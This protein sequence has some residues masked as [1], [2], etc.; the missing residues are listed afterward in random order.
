MDC[1]TKNCSSP[2]G[3][4]G[5]EEITALMQD[6]RNNPPKSLGG[7][8]V[9]QRDDFEQAISIAADGTTTPLDFPKANVLR[10]TLD[11][12]STI[13]VRPSGTEPKIKYYFSVNQPLKKEDDYALAK[14]ELREKCINLK[15]VVAKL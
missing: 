5:A 6:L 7:I 12:G 9:N 13:A 15:N 2:K 14:Q 1:I 4:Q 10:F 11:D 8:A 3:K